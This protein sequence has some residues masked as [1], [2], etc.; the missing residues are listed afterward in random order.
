MNGGVI[1]M[2][3]ETVYGIAASIQN[4]KGLREIFSIKERPFFDPLI[5]HIADLEQKDQ[6]VREWP[7]L[8]GIFANAFWPGPLTM[9]LAKSASISS[10]I[11]SGLDTV[12][13]RMP[14]HPIAQRL[15]REC[16]VPL[17]APS[18]NKF[19]KTSPTSADHVRKSFR[20]ENL[21]ILDGGPSELGLESTVIAF[22]GEKE[23]SI[24]RPGA[25][26]KEMLVD[27]AKEKNIIISVERKESSASPGHTEHHY[28]PAIPLVIVKGDGGIT[29]KIREEIC[30]D[31]CLSREARGQELRLNENPKV[32][33][34]ELYAHLRDCADLGAEY[35]YV[36]RI[37]LQ[38][39]GLWD[40][41]WDRL[42]RAASKSYRNLD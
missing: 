36:K 16:G 3:T 22:G 21:Y 25:I 26:T 37:S 34:R 14:K 32:A 5:V 20:G 39:G 31:F 6:V 9:V 30:Q 28:M 2:P 33:A 8:A 40:A 13:L 4:Q 15:I 24:L 11:T 41:I 17:A 38:E 1:A 7:V 19:G 35:I 27:A 10:L 23:I 18:A 29:E 12:G 42:G